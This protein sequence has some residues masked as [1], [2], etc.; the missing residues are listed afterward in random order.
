MSGAVL[1]SFIFLIGPVFDSF[2][3]A[4]PPDVN[5]NSLSPEEQAEILKNLKSPEEIRDEVTQITYIMA[6]LAGVICITGFLQYGFS[7]HAAASIATKTKI[8]YLEAILRQECAWFDMLNYAELS[9]RL[10]KETLAIQR[11][12]GEKYSQILFTIAMSISGLTLGFTKGWLLAFAML[13]IA[14]IMMVGIMVFTGFMGSKVQKQIK[15]YGQ[16]AGYAEQALSSIRVVVAFGQEM[17][18]KT[19]YTAFLEQARVIGRSASIATGIAL[20]F[21]IFCIYGAYA[22]AFYMGGLYV[23]KGIVNSTAGR[24][25]TAGDTISVFFGVLFG[26]FALAGAS[27]QFTAIIEGKAAGRLA[28]DVIN[29]KPK[30][31][32]DSDTGQKHVVQGEIEFRNVSFYYPSRTDQMILKNLNIK[33]KAGQTTAIVGPSGSGKSTI[34]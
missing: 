25:Y 29:R 28:F 12:I 11:A 34:V 23:D 22:Y 6:G 16:S 21:F 2:A 19:N 15:A 24:V 32:Q 9:A 30:I 31:N 18:E 17:T 7:I 10:S 33:F 3:P 8:A 4:I 5:F 20:G 26:M 13:G 27:P 14:P 1:P